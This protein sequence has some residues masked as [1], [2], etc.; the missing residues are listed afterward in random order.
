[1]LKIKLERTD[2]RNKGKEKERKLASKR[3]I[4]Y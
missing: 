2:G 1:M 3:E 4:K